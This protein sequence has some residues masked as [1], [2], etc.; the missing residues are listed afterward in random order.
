MV[1]ERGKEEVWVIM[2]KGKGGSMSD[3]VGKG[4]GGSM[5]DYVGKS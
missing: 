2:G 1:G 4:K 5:G 3:Y